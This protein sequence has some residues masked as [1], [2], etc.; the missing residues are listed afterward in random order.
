MERMKSLLVITLVLF[1][2]LNYSAYSQI[3]GEPVPSY[4]PD[5]TFVFNSPRPLINEADNPEYLKHAIGLDLTFSNN[6]F[7][8]GG[9]LHQ[10]LF[11]EVNGFVNLYVSGARN[12]D[13]FEQ[14]D[15]AY[16]DY[17]VYGKVNRVFMMPLTF[18][19][20][21]YMFTKEISESFRPFI[22]A[23]AG[24]TFIFTTPYDKEFFSAFAN[25]QSYIRFGGF[26]GFGTYISSKGNNIMGLHVRY[27]WIPFGGKGIESVINHPMTD[28]GGLYLS[29]SVGSLF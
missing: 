20:E 9:F 12:T 18:G 7:G 10:K 24:P 11:D 3:K 23:G 22:S 19:V 6:G 25:T 16:Q 1:C 13:E 27:Y 26:L 2:G 17:K 5:S 14:W 28:L 29:L 4:N 21:K 8:L 15:P